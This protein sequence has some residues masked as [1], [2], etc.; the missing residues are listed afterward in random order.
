MRATLALNEL[1]RAGQ[2]GNP[3]QEMIGI[4]QSMLKQLLLYMYYFSLEHI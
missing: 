1:M 4:S 2:E 3:F